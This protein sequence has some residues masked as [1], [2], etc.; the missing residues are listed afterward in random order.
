[1][2]NFVKQ[3]KKKVR[4]LSNNHINLDMILRTLP[5]LKLGSFE[6]YEHAICGGCGCRWTP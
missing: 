2:F 5:K 1:M 4:D 6:N 3:E